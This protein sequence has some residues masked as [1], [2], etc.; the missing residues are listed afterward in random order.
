[1]Y[2]FSDLLY[3]SGSLSQYRFGSSAA[4]FSYRFH[5]TAMASGTV[6]R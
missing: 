3:W 1:M 4:R 6:A 2:P 5:S